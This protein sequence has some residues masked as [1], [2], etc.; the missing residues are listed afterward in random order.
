MGIPQA[1][2]GQEIPFRMLD[3]SGSAMT[4]LALN[5]FTMKVW[6]PGFTA[7]GNTVNASPVREL[8]RGWYVYAA[9]AADIDTPG[10]NMLQATHTGVTV[11]REFEVD[12]YTPA[13]A[14]PGHPAA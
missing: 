6:K 3:G 9:G 1:Q 14:V 10:L 5:G 2:A 8:T 13:P 11:E 4:G 7:W 12:P